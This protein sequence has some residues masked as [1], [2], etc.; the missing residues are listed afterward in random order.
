MPLVQELK[1]RLSVI[2]EAIKIFSETNTNLMSKLQE[3][4]YSAII[5]LEHAALNS[6]PVAGDA[7]LTKLDLKVRPKTT[8]TCRPGIWHAR[9][10]SRQTRE[11]RTAKPDTFSG[12]AMETKALDALVLESPANLLGIARKDVGLR[13]SYSVP[14]NLHLYKIEQAMVDLMKQ[15]TSEARGAV[16]RT[17]SGGSVYES[18]IRQPLPLLRSGSARS[19]R[20][21]TRVGSSGSSGMQSSNRPATLTEKRIRE[22]TDRLLRTLF[23][24]SINL[25]LIQECKKMVKDVETLTSQDDNDEGFLNSDDEME[26]YAE[27]DKMCLA[28]EENED[29]NLKWDVVAA[30]LINRTALHIGTLETSWGL[31]YKLLCSV[32]EVQDT[33][34]TEP[35]VTMENVAYALSCISAQ[36]KKLD[37]DQVLEEVHQ[38]QKNLL[39][40]IPREK[41]DVKG[42]TVHISNLLSCSQ[43][44]RKAILNM[45]I[46]DNLC[47]LMVCLFQM[48]FRLCDLVVWLIRLVTDNVQKC[49]TCI[50]ADD[51]TFIFRV[52][53]KT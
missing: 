43:S 31:L 29:N 22:N 37:L 41:Q 15:D 18:P 40:A 52:V 27:V 47:I 11:N 53:A 28:Y 23:D 24:S 17:R 20:T 35:R 30:H 5:K 39:W 26:L 36:T 44:F 12:L 19:N 4:L 34:E 2:T 21:L 49:L 6:K 50:A 7:L 33:T 25:D 3:Q 8:S 16:Q 13:Q 45:K 1:G 10:H 38:A 51:D 42:E 32:A 14:E 48:P 46:N 9:H